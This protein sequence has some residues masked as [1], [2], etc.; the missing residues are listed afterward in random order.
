[1]PRYKV[2]LINLNNKNDK[3][4]VTVKARSAVHACVI[5]HKNQ[6]DYFAFEANIIENSSDKN[7]NTN[8]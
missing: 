2:S 6:P 8:S 7:N 1:M 4:Y 3:I 5:A